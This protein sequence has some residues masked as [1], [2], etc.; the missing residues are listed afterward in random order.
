MHARNAIFHDGAV[1]AR[2]KSHV[3][4]FGLVKLAT[5]CDSVGVSQHARSKGVARYAKEHGPLHDCI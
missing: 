2:V 4:R 1:S 5:Q 3:V